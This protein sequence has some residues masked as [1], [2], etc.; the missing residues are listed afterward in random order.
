MKN[1][2]NGVV[3]LDRKLYSNAI[4]KIISDTSKCEKLS[5]DATLKREASLQR[6]L[7]YLKQKNFSNKIEY[8]KF[9]PCGSAASRIYG[10]PKMHKLSSSGS[11]PKLRPI[12]SSIGT[13]NYNLARFLCDLSFTFSS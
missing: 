3:S 12:V 11:L 6:F 9:Y 5:E 1:K 10:T 7:H 4:E 13:F 8:D 2:D